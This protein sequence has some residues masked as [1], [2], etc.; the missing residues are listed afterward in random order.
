MNYKEATVIGLA[1]NG[2]G[3]V[4]LVVASIGLQFG[5]INDHIFSI[6]VFVAF[7]TTSMPP[8]SLKLFLDKNS[9]EK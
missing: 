6:L 8:I 4:E 3:A 5:L 9:L 1:M 7:V 2:R